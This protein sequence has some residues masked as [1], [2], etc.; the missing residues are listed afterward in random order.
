MKWLLYTLTFA[1][2][3]V[4]GGLVV[5]EMAIRKIETPIN[6]LVDAL[7]GDDSY[8]GGATKTAVNAYLRGN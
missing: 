5:R 1:A 6:G 4:V 8:A 2:G 7:L 3:A